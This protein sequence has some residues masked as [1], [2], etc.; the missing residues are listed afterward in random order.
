MKTMKSF[1]VMLLVATMPMLITSCEKDDIKEP[2]SSNKD[3]DDNE[4]YEDLIIGEWEC[5][6]LTYTSEYEGE[7]DSDSEDL[8][9]EDFIWEFDEDGKL[10]IYYDGD[11]EGK[12]DY[13]VK[14]KKLYTE[15]VEEMIDDEV[16]YF[17]IKKL[18]EKKLVLQFEYEDEREDYYMSQEYSFER[19]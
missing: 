7:E 14:G 9:G 2:T 12:Y 6:E 18:T 13:S 3:N 10:T 17:T 11:R 19:I 15:F 1:L 8:S 4:E 5:V 16:E